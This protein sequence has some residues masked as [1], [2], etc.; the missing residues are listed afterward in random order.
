LRDA[1]FPARGIGLSAEMAAVCRAKDPDAETGELFA[2]LAARP[3]E[4]LGG[5]LPPRARPPGVAHPP[6]A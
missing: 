5:T 1:S 2:L 6:P 4:S 3:D